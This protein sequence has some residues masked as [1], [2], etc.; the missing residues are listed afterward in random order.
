[1]VGVHP[2]LL[3]VIASIEVSEAI[4]ILTGKQPR[5]ANKLFHFDIEHVEVNE[6]RF[7]KVDQC[8]VCGSKPS[9]YPKPIN[10]TLVEEICGRS[11]KKVFVIIPRKSLQ[12]NM[13]E[14]QQFLA[15]KG[16]KVKISASLGI[17]FDKDT[18]VSVSILKSG[19]MIVEGLKEKQEALSFFRETLVGGLGV[20]EELIS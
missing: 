18:Q 17:T 4:K 2:S 10:R 16:F 3:A 6:V 15:K 14:L 11:G 8:P 5:L 20:S 1:M 13:A 12:I 19:V 9:D 7:S